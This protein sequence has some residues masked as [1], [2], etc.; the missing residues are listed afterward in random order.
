VGI[1][2]FLKGKSNPPPGGNGKAPAAPMDRKTAGFAKVARDKHAQQ[3]DRSEA[4]HALADMKTAD[5]A[6]GLLP[7]FRFSIDP[8]IHDSD[9]KDIAFAG[10]VAAGKE[11]VPAI[12]EYCEQAEGKGW[13]LTWPIK[14]LREVLD[15][16]EY[17]AELIDLLGGFDTEY[18]RNTDPKL[19][20]VLALEELKHE[21]VRVAVEPFLED[22][23]ETVRFHAVETIFRQSDTRS[24]AP[25]LHLLKTE[26][27]VRVKNKVA[28]GLVLRG[29]VVPEDERKDVTRALSDTSGFRL[30][31]EGKLEKLE[32]E[33]Y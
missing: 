16:D 6:A 20:L 32:V 23:N 11:A 2:D 4:L 3:Y 26:E 30:T 29:W 19:Q 27:S 13:P 22:V 10:L 12:V 8:S 15:D 28:D 17:R 5:A 21:E 33:E 25:L 7:R 31:G 14:V 24:L 9:E 1:F 18:A